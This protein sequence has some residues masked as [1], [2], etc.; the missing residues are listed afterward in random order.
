MCN[1]QLFTMCFAMII[2]ATVCSAEISLRD[3][4]KPLGYSPT[5]VKSKQTLQLSS[6]LISSERKVAVINGQ[7]VKEQ[8]S[9]KGFDG[10]MVKK[11]LPHAVIVKKN[12]K[13]W[14][15]SLQTQ[16]FNRKAN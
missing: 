3:P 10:V 13:T 12:G 9:I 4:T 5:Q 8:E 15:L 14:R 11:I 1:Y 6:V 16:S 2:S 7:R